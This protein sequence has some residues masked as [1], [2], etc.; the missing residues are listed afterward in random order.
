MGLYTSHA[1]TAGGRN[2]VPV[3]LDLDAPSIP[4]EGIRAHS[5]IRNVNTSLLAHSNSPYPSPP[6]PPPPTPLLLCRNIPLM[7][8]DLWWSIFADVIINGSCWFFLDYFLVFLSSCRCTLDVQRVSYKAVPQKGA[9]RER[10]RER[11]RE[12]LF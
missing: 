1:R 3:T 7:Y 11:E 10:E 8:I 12:R 4:L 2:S 9:R 5:R 6:P